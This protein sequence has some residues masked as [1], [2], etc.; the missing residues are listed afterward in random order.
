MNPNIEPTAMP[1][2]A[3]ADK[4]PPLASLAAPDD[5]AEAVAVDVVKVMVA[6]IVGNFT[7]AHLNETPEL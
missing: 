2:F 7:P 4:P 6:V 5:D 3:P 1:A